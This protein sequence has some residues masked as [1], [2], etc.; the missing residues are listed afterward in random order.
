VVAEGFVAGGP[1]GPAWRRV[2]VPFR[3]LFRDTPGFQKRRMGSLVLSGDS[4]EAGVV[5]L[6]PIRLYLTAEDAKAEEGAVP[7]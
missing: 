1:L 2:V 3:R 4:P 6:G 7:K 5:K